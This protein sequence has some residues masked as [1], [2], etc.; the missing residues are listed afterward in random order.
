MAATNANQ[1]QQQSNMAQEL[2]S[3]KTPAA[4]DVAVAP[5]P[6]DAAPENPNL[7]LP[8]DK[9]TIIVFLRHCGC[10]FA[11]KTFKSMTT[12]SQLY[13]DQIHFIAVS[14]SS[15]E[16]TEHWVVSV[17]GNWD[18]QVVVDYERD[19]Y[20]QYGLGVSNTWHVLSPA[21]LY[22]V[23][24]LGKDEGIWNRP[25]QS[26]SRWQKGGAFAVAPE[27]DGRSG[28]EVKWAQVAASADD[29]PDLDKAIAALGFEVKTKPKVEEVKSYGFP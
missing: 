6:G 23:L 20:A 19:L 21:S 15:P 22:K 11:E 27:Q 28:W 4:K 17:G 1:D 29:M 16:A 24:R 10:P 12:L 25:T 8:T 5:K 3:W 26:G 18:V 9:P 2:E 7:K 13:K 14:H